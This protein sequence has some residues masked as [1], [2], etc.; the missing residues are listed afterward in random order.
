MKSIQYI[1]ILFTLFAFLSCSK[2]EKDT[3]PVEEITITATNFTITIDENPQ[4]G[5]VIGIIDASTNSGTLQFEITQ[6]NPIG[7]LKVGSTTG[8]ISVLEASLFNYNENPV[9]SATIEIVN[10]I[11]SR[12]V[13]ISI[14]LNPLENIYEGNVYLQTQQEVNDFGANNYTQ[15]NGLL[16][17]GHNEETGINDIIDLSPLK[18][19]GI[20]NNSLFIKNN[21][22]LISTEGLNV[23]F[24]L[25]QLGIFNNPVLESIKGFS[26]ITSI[27]F[28]TISDNELLTDVYQLSQITQI[29]RSLVLYKCSSLPNLEW[30]QNITTIGDHLT[31][32]DCDSLTNI[33]GLNNLTNFSDDG[34]SYIDIRNNDSLENINGLQNINAFVYMVSIEQN[35]SLQNINGL[36]NINVS[37]SLTITRN[38][39]LQNLIGLGATSYVSLNINIEDNN[40]LTNL[41]GLDNLIEFSGT[42]TLKNNEN[43]KSL[44]GLEGLDFIDTFRIE[45]N[46]T[47]NDF[48]AIEV[49]LTEDPSS[50]FYT[51]GNSYNPTK[52]D[53]IDGNCML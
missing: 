40:S 12:N 7:A 1:I 3:E 33:D 53:I 35:E 23:T 14:T 37:Q 24:I 50:Y 27:P 47:L 4:N 49:V 8:E 21:T 45:N 46:L 30:L 15:I 16:S 31:I 6:E 2:D 13:N 34:L 26:S 9:I 38:A 36:S 25:G 52:Q 51:N 28:L 39:S 44:N 10:G 11:V 29:E 22:V 19:I 17:I 42:F 5:Q 43:L 41:E 18:S 20:V 48:C 32:Q